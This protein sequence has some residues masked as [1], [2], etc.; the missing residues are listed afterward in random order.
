M[1][2][3]DDIIKNSF[4]L[5]T[6]HRQRIWWITS[7]VF[8]ITLIITAFCMAFR[9]K[10]VARTK[11]TI[12]PTRSEIGFA[13]MRPDM[14]LSPA[15]LLGQ[16]Y[17]E[18]MTSRTLAEDVARTL[19]AESG[20]ELKNGGVLGHIRT[21]AIAPMFGLVNQFLTFV[22][23]GRWETP[24]PF[25]ALVGAIQSR[26]TVQNLPGSF[27]YQVAVTWENPKI[28]TT[29]A[30]LLAE[31]HVQMTLQANREEMKTM[32]GYVE[33]R[34]TETKGDLALLEKKIKD[35]RVNEKLYASTTDM[36]LGLQERSVYQRD[37]NAT[38][39]NRAQLDAKIDAL[40]SY[41]TPTAL[42]AIE[43]ERSELKTRE[44]AV[45][46]VIGEQMAV[47]DK[48]PAKEAGLL[49]LYRERINLEHTLSSLEDRLLDTKVSEM[50]QISSA[51]II[52]RAIVPIYPESPLLLRNAVTS[53]L[54]GLLLS[55]GYVL[56]LEAW[57]P[58]L[59]S[60]DDLGHGGGDMIGL[61]PFVA[62]NGV[63][64]P[65]PDEEHQ[66]RMTEFFQSVAHGHYGTVAHRRT[67]K[68]H[69]EHLLMRLTDGVGARICMFVSLSGGEGKTY[70]IEHLAR[71][72]K[73]SGLK[74][75][76]IDA[77]FSSP[78]LHLKF[79]KPM[80]AGLAEMLAGSVAAKDAII[81]AD[82]GINL[83]DAGIKRLPQSKLAIETIQQELSQL[84]A[85]YDLILIDTAALRADSSVPRF[86]P[87]ASDLVCVFDATKSCR[88]DADEVRQRL[89]NMAPHMKVV[90]NKKLHA[91]DHLFDAGKNGH[92]VDPL[93]SRPVTRPV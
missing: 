12:L 57:K 32:R 37:L 7:R 35:Y 84:K 92:S 60:R 66:G 15:T 88:S 52:D 55:V 34:I 64:H 2:S 45:E 70:L 86:L 23:T 1:T 30:N 81:V 19:Q 9:P 10:F 72:A 89:G 13:S 74:V 26:T 25:R 79:G 5:L 58:G 33:A 3:Y 14:L 21:R 73:E 39:V 69:L 6:Y 87:L 54:V 76:I 4:R 62:T 71:L 85:G 8:I 42:A 51:R 77:N 59:R 31:H 93:V 29:I 36:D 61:V 20:A 28:A 46:K 44:A 65:D 83:I 90:L 75:L 41:Q 16:T 24:D 27:V 17:S 38:R 18:T 82:G 78:A 91:G 49:D 50:A 47:L 11:L 40:K 67:A 53:L 68:R 80:A 63:D 43:A 22:N 56:M 48:L